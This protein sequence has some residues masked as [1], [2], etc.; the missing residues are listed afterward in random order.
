MSSCMQVKLSPNS[1]TDLLKRVI[2]SAELLG[3][4]YLRRRP[5]PSIKTCA[6]NP[7]AKST[8]PTTMESQLANGSY[9]WIPSVIQMVPSHYLATT[10]KSEL[11][12]ELMI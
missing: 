9:L 11:K 3:D 5:L 4:A 12:L 10:L 2:S 8:V 1:I 7:L 6:L